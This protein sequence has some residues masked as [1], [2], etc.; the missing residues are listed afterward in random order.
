MKTVNIK[1]FRD[2]KSTWGQALAIV[3][4]IAAG[5]STFIMALTTLDT[6]VLTRDAYYRDFRFVDVFA[7][8]NRAPEN[9][10]GE[11]E[12]I[13]GVDKVQTR[14]VA[15]VKLSIENFNE[16]VIGQV[17]SVPDYGE[18]L[19][20]RLIIMKGRYIDPGRDDEVI[21]NEV[22][23]EAH[24][25]EPGETLEMIIKGRLQRLSIVGIALS[26]EFI[27]QMAPGA[28]VPDFKR[29]GVLWMSRDAL[30]KAFDMDN[31]FNDVALTLQTG[32]NAR[33]VVMKLDLL[34]Q[35]Y[36]GRDAQEREWQPSH[37]IFQSDIAQLGQ[38]ATMFSTIFLGV[39]AF[40]LNIVVGRMISTQREI[41][42]ALKAFG[43]SNV[44]V[45]MH[46]LSYVAVIVTIGLLLERRI[47][48]IV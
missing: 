2:L 4:V 20:N 6:L 46:Y 1:L 18:P 9:L 34:L 22:F 12:A 29:F 28:I 5:I 42:A 45:G 3:L 35:P 14:V 43:Y 37:R 44:D 8:V 11:I 25:L 48:I 19:V 26:P 31:A 40:L 41:I 17:L 23:A 24:Q 27:Y 47:V 32:A 39:A 21:L 7:S 38:M 16:P 36:G 15:L 10:R 13:D 33:D 30:G